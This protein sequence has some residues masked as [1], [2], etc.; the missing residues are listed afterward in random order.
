M[1]YCFSGGSQQA[2]QISLGKRSEPLPSRSRL[3]AFPPRVQTTLPTQR[4]LTARYAARAPALS[5]RHARSRQLLAVGPLTAEGPAR[6]SSSMPMVKES[7]ATAANV[8]AVTA[9]Q[10]PIPARL[11]FPRA[12]P[13]S[14]ALPRPPLPSAAEDGGRQPAPPRR[15]H[16]RGGERSGGSSGRRPRQ[17]NGARRRRSLR[18][19]APLGRARRHYDE[20]P[21]SGLF[22][23]TATT[24]C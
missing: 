5:A 20:E 19:S 10:I 7:R 1:P 6:L 24:L 11:G 15:F 9:T 12:A 13:L 2:L 21:I 23:W 4:P 18:P 22:C 3:T 17:R 14:P 16:N 8:A